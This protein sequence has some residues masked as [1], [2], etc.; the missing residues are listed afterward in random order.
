MDIPEEKVLQ[1][2]RFQ[3]RECERALKG[4]KSSTYTALA[5][6]AMF[7][8]PIATSKFNSFYMTV[9][10]HEPIAY[11]VQTSWWGFSEKR[12]PLRWKEVEGYESPG[13]MAQDAHGEWYLFITEEYDPGY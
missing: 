13:W 2:M 4:Y 5:L 8:V 6:V 10:P 11:Y 3:A 7:L 12:I 1:A 9:D